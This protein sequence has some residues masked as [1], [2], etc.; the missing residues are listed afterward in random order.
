MVLCPPAVFVGWVHMLWEWDDC[1]VF[2][3][4]Y[5]SSYRDGG[6]GWCVLGFG[7]SFCSGFLV[8][9][10]YCD[11]DPIFIS[12]EGC[13]EGPVF[14]S[15]VDWVWEGWFQERPPCRSVLVGF[16]HS[17]GDFCLAVSVYFG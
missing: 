15:A 2:A 1:Y 4:I 3:S 12:S 8:F 16:V 14:R 10:M 9:L 7:V 6:C 5:R 13:V 11:W 17:V